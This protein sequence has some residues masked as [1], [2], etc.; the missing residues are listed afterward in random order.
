M[1]LKMA[2]GSFC[3]KVSIMAW[4]RLLRLRLQSYLPDFHMLQ[5]PHLNLLLCPSERRLM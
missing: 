1:R 3:S 5:Q 4:G 2:T